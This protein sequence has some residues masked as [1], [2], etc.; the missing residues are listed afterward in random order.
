MIIYIWVTHKTKVI[1]NFEELITIY[2]YVP[3]QKM[4]YFNLADSTLQAHIFYYDGGVANTMQIFILIVANSS[5][6][7]LVGTK[8]GIAP[9]GSTKIPLNE[10]YFWQCSRILRES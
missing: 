10:Q 1:F 7:S 6:W 3:T 5:W 4:L 9:A 8:E 2:P